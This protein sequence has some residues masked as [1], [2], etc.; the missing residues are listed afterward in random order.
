MTNSKELQAPINTTL[1]RKLGWNGSF[2]NQLAGMASAGKNVVRVISVQRSSFL[3]SDGEREWLCKASGTL[4]HAEDGGYPVTGDWALVRDAVV[5]DIIP[6]KN[7]LSRGAAGSRGSQTGIAS[8]EQAIAA[9]IDT[10]F[11]VCGLDRDFNVR[12]VERY[13]TLVY[14]CGLIPVIV[15]TKC[16]L[17]EDPESCCA[18]VESV[19]FGVPIVLSSSLDGRGKSEVESHL[20]S[21][22]TV[23]MLGSSGAG[24]STLANMLYGSDIQTTG[25]VSESVGKGRHLTTTREMIPMPQGG[26]LMDNP[27]IREI[28]FFEDG[29][30]VEAAFPEIQALAHSCRFS[31]CT[32]TVEPGCAVVHAAGAGELDAGRLESYQKMKREMEYLSARQGKSA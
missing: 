2:A 11:I 20:G 25:A 24:K 4:L 27:G 3:V 16:D 18:E 30:G 17:H 6:R 31:D 8:R 9:N 10:V 29:Q 14:N 13:L 5:Y 28:A 22:Q 12:R 7:L 21:G 19:A 1:L 23:A 15:L 26:M 32:H